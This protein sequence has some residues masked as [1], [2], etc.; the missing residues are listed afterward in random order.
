MA[1]SL[2]H[3][4]SLI[5][6]EFLEKNLKPLYEVDEPLA[7]AMKGIRGS[8]YNFNFIKSA[9]GNIF[10]H[11]T[12]TP[13]YQD[14]KTELEEKK[15]FF[16]QNFP[17][18]PVLFI[19]GFANAVLI[20]HL[21]RNSK[22]KRIVVFEP[23]LEL[24]YYALQSFD[25]ARDLKNERLIVFY[26]PRIIPAQLGTLFS[27]KDISESVKTYNLNSACE[28][29]NSH[30]MAEIQKL[31]QDMMEWI[32]FAFIRKG[33]DPKDSLIGIEHSLHNL[34][35]MLKNPSL[36]DLLCLR[37]KANKTA[38][39]VSTG[40]S[41]N[42]QLPLLKQY[43][44]KASIFCADSAY[45]ILHREGISPDYVL[46]IERIP[47]TSELFNNDFGEFNNNILFILTSFT[48]EN[49]LK[50]IEKD[51]RKYL[52]AMRPSPF[53]MSFKLDE[54]GYLGHHHSV[55]N[56]SY[57]LAS[58][59]EHERI[60]LIGQDLAYSKEGSSHSKGYELSYIHEKDYER[61]RG[62]FLIEA[63]GG[64]DM[65]ES[66]AVWT[67]FKQ[68]LEAD[69]AMAKIKFK[70]MAYN[71][72]EGGARIEG[73]IEIPFKKA[74][75]EFL[76]KEED[77][78]PLKMPSSLSEDEYKT[79]LKDIRIKFEKL[80][81]R[82]SDY[83][84]EIKKEL[85]HLTVILPRDYELEKLDFKALKKS[86]E[87]LQRFYAKFHKF[88]LL[89]EVS[90]VIYYQNNCELIRLDCV[91]CKSE[92]DEKRALIELVSNLANFFIEVGEYVYTQNDT[93]LKELRKW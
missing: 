44:N 7:R 60:I 3:P 25:F 17:K 41:L 50:Y 10:H 4:Q 88:S 34:P 62:R 27:Y 29:Y 92:E 84:E 11:P 19:F 45:H 30:Y 81:K 53:C 5:N 71:C 75:E 31:N 14:L 79:K 46:S 83:F 13:M 49:T 42:K 69:I 85:E 47:L 33:N 6:N 66:S 64:G 76:A 15:N 38:I 21:L 86:K 56:M 54:F 32:R 26:T 57:E 63:Y 74:C 78:K 80:I 89:T 2:T 24:F 22:H 18:H 72:T 8:K 40:P 12:K 68:G 1:E 93:M 9:D 73:S 28:F 52:I 43:Q 65:V 70:T 59:L 58:Y 36:Q 61:D 87:R 51:D 82:S 55:A 90:D 20:S 67:L 39:V 48:H 37:K 91:V 16:D 77:K 23:E 35:K